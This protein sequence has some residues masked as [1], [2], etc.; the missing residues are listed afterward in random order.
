MSFLSR[1]RR[2]RRRQ[3]IRS[4]LNRYK[5]VWGYIHIY[6]MCP[7]HRAAISMSG[8]NTPTWRR[9]WRLLGARS[10]LFKNFSVDCNKIY[11]EY[12]TNTL[13][14]VVSTIVYSLYSQGVVQLVSLTFPVRPP[15]TILWLP[16]FILVLIVS[17]M[18]FWPVSKHLSIS[19]CVCVS[20]AHLIESDRIQGGLISTQ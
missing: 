20:D 17:F 19:T 15:S 16:G 3:W 6:T 14:Q 13:S 8:R 2:R 4:R 10:S 5:C 1:R 11:I 12:T 9:C 7:I 18:A